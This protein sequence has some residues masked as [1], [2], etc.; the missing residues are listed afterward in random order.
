MHVELVREGEWAMRFDPGDRFAVVAPGGGFYGVEGEPMGRV[1]SD[2]VVLVAGVPDITWPADSIDR[3][4]GD[5]I[6]AG[7][8]ADD[9]DTVLAVW[10]VHR[11]GNAPT[12]YTLL[13]NWGRP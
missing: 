13:V 4:E 9:S 2:V 10:D 8:I 7:W 6:G 5:H 11:V 12:A 3:G 1:V